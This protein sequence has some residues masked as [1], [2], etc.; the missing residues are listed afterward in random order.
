[1]YLHTTHAVRGLIC[2]AHIAAAILAAKHYSRCLSARGHPDCIL[3]YLYV[4][5]S[6]AASCPSLAMFMSVTIFGVSALQLMDETARVPQCFS[7]I[8]NC[9]ASQWKL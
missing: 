6:M 2:S 7:S 4:Q 5:P 3:C 8:P 9:I 1:M